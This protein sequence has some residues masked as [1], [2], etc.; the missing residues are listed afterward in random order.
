MKDRL[1]RAAQYGLTAL[2]VRLQNIELCAPTTPGTQMWMCPNCGEVHTKQP[3][4]LTHYR[5]RRSINCGWHG[6]R[7]ELCRGD[8]SCLTTT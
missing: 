2:Q 4:D 6:D 7:H 5:C 8:L 1:K 3:L